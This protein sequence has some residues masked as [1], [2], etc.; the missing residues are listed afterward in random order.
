MQNLS[1][2]TNAESRFISPENF[3]G[4]KG[5]GGMAT[6]GTSVYAPNP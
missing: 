3:T 5:K 6:D 4:E 2:L 1:M